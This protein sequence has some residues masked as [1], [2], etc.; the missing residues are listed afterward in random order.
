MQCEDESAQVE[1]P[2]GQIGKLEKDGDDCS[3]TETEGT[4]AVQWR[5]IEDEVK[6]VTLPSEGK[7]H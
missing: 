3:D 4:E 5:V 2:K 6:D 1:R 7:R